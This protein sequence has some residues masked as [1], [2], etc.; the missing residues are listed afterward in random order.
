MTQ[1]KSWGEANQR[2][3]VHQILKWD[4]TATIQT[5]DL[6]LTTK[7]VHVAV[8]NQSGKTLALTLAHLLRIDDTNASAKVGEGANSFY[9]VSVVE[10]GADGEK[11]SIRH[12]LPADPEPDTATDLEIDL[13][14]NLI[15]ITL[16][17]DASGNPDNNKNTAKLIANA[18]NDEETGLEG[19]TATYDGD[20]SG[21]FTQAH[22]EPIPFTGGITERWA[23]LYDS[24]GQELSISI[25][26]NTRR[27]YGPFYHFPRFLG[28]R[29]TLTAGTAPEDETITIVQIVEG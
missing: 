5:V 18:I 23:Q 20:G 11:Y 10:P 27:V 17:V 12:V 21:V 22:E 8:D 6:P 13:T 19:F 15:T 24:E 4:G 28:G 29:V 26:N 9:T 3:L 16:A 2:R 14:D 1:P 25:T 7:P